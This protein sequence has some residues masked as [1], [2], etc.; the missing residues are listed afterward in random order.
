VYDLILRIIEIYIARSIVFGIADNAA[1][2]LWFLAFISVI[3]DLKSAFVKFD[4]PTRA[5][6]TNGECI[7]ENMKRYW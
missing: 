7:D 5:H 3:S 6:E 2:S 1:L 4:L